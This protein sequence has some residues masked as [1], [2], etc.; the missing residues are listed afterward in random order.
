MVAYLFGDVESFAVCFGVVPVGSE[1]LAENGVVGLF[2][3]FGLLV[4]AG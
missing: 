2:K 3:A 4:K 1:Y